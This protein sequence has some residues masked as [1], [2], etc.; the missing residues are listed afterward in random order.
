MV[1]H[2]QDIDW[3]L[4][5]FP[6]DDPQRATYQERAIAYQGDCGCSTGAAFMAVS[7]LGV[8]IAF[9]V[10]RRIAVVRIVLAMATVLLATAVGKAVGLAVA[11]L[12][13]ALL[14]HRIAVH[15]RRSEA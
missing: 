14:R 11:R 10:D 15:L 12:R 1:A 13:L 9:A 2:S 3:L 8:A 6:S 7:I 4:G 5:Q